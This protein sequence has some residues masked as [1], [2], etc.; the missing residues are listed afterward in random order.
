[1]GNAAVAA[2]HLAEGETPSEQ[3][4]RCPALLVYLLGSSPCVTSVST[5]V[6][7]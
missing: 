7:L 3:A 4:A 5:F 1:M 6:P 2:A